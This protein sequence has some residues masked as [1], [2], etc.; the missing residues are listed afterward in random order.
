MV[1]TRNTTSSTAAPAPSGALTVL[2]PATN[3][4]PAQGHPGGVLQ[5]A[6]TNSVWSGTLPAATGFIRK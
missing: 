6:Y 4:Q 5:V 2:A 1:D 3:V